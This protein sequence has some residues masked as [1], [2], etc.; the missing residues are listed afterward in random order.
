MSMISSQVSGYIKKA[1]MRFAKEEN[2][3]VL[4]IQ[5]LITE[6]RGSNPAYAVM[7]DYSPVRGI[8]IK[9]ILGG[10]DLMGFG[11]K[12]N[13]W[14]NNYFEKIRGEYKMDGSNCSLIIVPLDEHAKKLNVYIYRDDKPIKQTSVEDVF[15]T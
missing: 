4:S 2:A 3:E 1:L 15:S 14:L 11:K 8:K 13:T 5:I 10:L 12:A 6:R 7:K 9:D